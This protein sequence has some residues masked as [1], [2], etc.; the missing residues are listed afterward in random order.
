MVSIVWYL[1]SLRTTISSIWLSTY[2]KGGGNTTT[3]TTT[4]TTATYSKLLKKNITR[5]EKKLFHYF[6][7]NNIKQV[8]ITLVILDW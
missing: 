6:C 8:K 2:K 4:T 7:Q 3:T 1:V 5:Q